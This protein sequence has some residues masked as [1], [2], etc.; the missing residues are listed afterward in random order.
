MMGITRAGDFGIDVL[1]INLHRRSPHARRR[2]A[3]ARPGRGEEDSGAYLPVPCLR[4]PNGALSTNYERPQ[5]IGKIKPTTGTS[6]CTSAPLLHLAKWSR[7]VE[8]RHRDRCPHPITSARSSRKPTRCPSLA[9]THEVCVFRP[10]PGAAMASALET[11][12]SGSSTTAFIHPTVSFPFNCSRRD[13]DRTTETESRQE[14]DAFMRRCWAITKEAESDP[15][16]VKTA[17]IM[18]E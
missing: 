10:E 2:W 12:E 11:L 1:H 14:L 18:R 13:H 16:L 7:R 6:A 5:S 17:P 3:G 15:N 8:V 4:E 9:D